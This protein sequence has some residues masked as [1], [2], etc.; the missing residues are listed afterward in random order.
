MK[1]QCCG[2]EERGSRRF[3]QCLKNFALLVVYILA[4]AVLAVLVLMGLAKYVD[5]KDVGTFRPK[6]QVIQV[7]L[8]YIMDGIYRF[9]TEEVEFNS[10]SDVQKI[11]LILPRPESGKRYI[12]GVVGLVK[13]DSSLINKNQE[14]RSD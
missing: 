14:G 8:H 9:N 1:N 3:S 7:N 4:P 12:R 10:D 2:R 5:T 6:E 11:V 13:A